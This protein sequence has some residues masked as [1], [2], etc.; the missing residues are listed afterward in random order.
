MECDIDEES[1]E[2]EG[3]CKA[4]Q[5]CVE[6]CMSGDEDWWKEFEEEHK[7]EKGV[8]AAGG[9]C[10]KQ[11]GKTEGFIWLGG[12]GEPF[13]DIQY[14]KNKYYSGGHAEWCKYDL[15]SFIRQRQEFEKGFNQEFAVWFFEKYLPNSAE[16]WEQSVS[17]IFE[18]YWNNVDNQMEIAHRMQCLEINDIGELMDY[19]LIEFNYDTEYGS[20]EYWEEAKEVRV[21]GLEEK[22]IIISPYMKVWIFPPEAFIRYEMKEAMK[23]HEF[24]GPPE[25]KMKRGNEEGLTAEEKEMIKRD[26]GFMN[27]IKEVADKYG[28]NVNAV[29]QFKD[30]ETNEVIFNL[31]VQVNEEDIMKMEPMLP[32]EVPAEDVRIEIDFEKIYDMIYFM[33]KEMNGA[34]IETP[35]WDR[36]PFGGQGIK[37]IIDGV[38]MWF[39][40][41]DIIN[42]AKVYPESAAGDVKDLFKKFFNIMSKEKKGREM[43]EEEKFEDKGILESKE[44]I[45]GEVIGKI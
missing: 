4:S 43:E 33:E 21:P 3:Q 17:G 32:E 1:R 22:V 39:M 41:Q 15:E 42:S 5:D 37:G 2:C 7:E 20:I 10:R 30:Y 23:N 25:E 26:R 11:Q 28:G 12:W 40:M 19:N 36:K 27:K 35:P 45:T 14:L 18:I 9:S 34:M 29:V 6:K 8:F 44:K 13:G 38:R 16:N 31:Y 24:P